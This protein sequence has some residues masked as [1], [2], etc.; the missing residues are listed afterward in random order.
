MLC[1][2]IAILSNFRFSYVRQRKRVD[3][4]IFISEVLSYK[5]VFMHLRVGSSFV[6]KTYYFKNRILSSLQ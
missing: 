3:D 4:E 1:D 6:L 2:V 5:P